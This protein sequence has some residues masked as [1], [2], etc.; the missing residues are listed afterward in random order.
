M[1]KARKRSR[2][3]PAELNGTELSDKTETI[4]TT[5]S[6]EGAAVKA[7]L[8]PPNPAEKHTRWIIAVHGGA[9]QGYLSD[10]SLK[11]YRECMKEACR[12]SAAALDSGCCAEE[13]V[14]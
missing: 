13:A 5:P 8:D 1:G 4:Q 6:T 12:R 10:T 14:T 9:A 7:S 3:L 2:E 11:K